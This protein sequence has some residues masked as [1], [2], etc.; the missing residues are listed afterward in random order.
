MFKNF[1]KAEVHESAYTRVRIPEYRTYIRINNKICIFYVKDTLAL[2]H[3][4]SRMF[5]EKRM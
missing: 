5:E 3:L 2:R 1:S 4:L